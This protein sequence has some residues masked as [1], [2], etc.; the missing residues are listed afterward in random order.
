MQQPGI[1]WGLIL[2]L[3][4][5]AATWSAIAITITHAFS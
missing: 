2:A 3:L 5:C 4:F 1:N